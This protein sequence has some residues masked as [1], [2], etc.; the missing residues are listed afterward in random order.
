MIDLAFEKNMHRKIRSDC[1]HE[2]AVGLQGLALRDSSMTV[3]KASSQISDS[4]SSLRSSGSSSS[5]L[6]S[7]TLK[8]TDTGET[9][10]SSAS[11]SLA[12]LLAL[13]TQ[14]QANHHGVVEVLHPIARAPSK[15]FSYGPTDQTILHKEIDENWTKFLAN[16]WEDGSLNGTSGE[17]ENEDQTHSSNSPAREEQEEPAVQFQRLRKMVGGDRYRHPEGMSASWTLEYITGKL[18]N[19]ADICGLLGPEAKIP[20]CG[21]LTYHDV[22]RVKYSKEILETGKSFTG[23]IRYS[24][25]ETSRRRDFDLAENRYRKLE[26]AGTNDPTEFDV[27]DLCDTYE[28]GSLGLGKGLGFQ[29]HDGP[30]WPEPPPRRYNKLEELPS[31]W[32]DTYLELER[33]RADER[34][35]TQ[36]NLAQHSRTVSKVHILAETLSEGQQLERVGAVEAFGPI[37]VMEQ[38]DGSKS[39]HAGQRRIKWKGAEEGSTQCR[40]SVTWDEELMRNVQEQ[41]H[42]PSTSNSYHGDLRQVKQSAGRSNQQSLGVEQKE[43]Q[44]QGDSVQ[45][46][47]PQEPGF[48]PHLVPYILEESDLQAVDSAARIEE[49]L[50]P[51]ERIMTKTKESPF[52]TLLKFTRKITASFVGTPKI[53]QKDIEQAEQQ[54]ATSPSLSRYTRQAS[55]LI[56]IP[57]MGM[58]EKAKGKQA[59]CLHTGEEIQAS[60]PISIPSGGMLEQGRARA[61]KAAS[62]Y[63]SPVERIATKQAK[64]PKKNKSALKG[65]GKAVKNEAAHEEEVDNDYCQLDLRAAQIIRPRLR[66]GQIPKPVLKRRVSGPNKK[67]ERNS[68]DQSCQQE[69][70]WED[71]SQ[72]DTLHAPAM[73][74]LQRPQNLGSFLTVVSPLMLQHLIEKQSTEQPSQPHELQRC[75][76]RRRS[77]TV[78][79]IPSLASMQQTIPLSIE[80]SKNISKTSEEIIRTP[81]GTETTTVSIGPN[82]TVVPVEG[83]DDS[84]FCERTLKPLDQDMSV[85]P[86][87]KFPGPVRRAT[88]VKVMPWMTNVEIRRSAKGKQKENSVSKQDNPMVMR[89]GF[90]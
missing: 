56:A 60:R 20:G 49:D 68:Q 85:K 35:D 31:K 34:L 54:Q 77:D 36:Q 80:N 28:Y 40:R 22:L 53:Q 72:Q 37:K 86:S 39:Q 64:K 3:S 89:G 47:Q 32:R 65:K 27:A 52:G 30:R 13:P 12:K 2:V 38:Q 19:M 61:K 71:I 74:S 11:F 51:V 42:P 44:K 15:R 55:Q 21:G 50:R 23:P 9:S 69:S 66:T 84:S 41:L 7:R 57:G 58:S 24:D 6:A 46:N 83:I 90:N 14:P 63:S 87:N 70:Q 79:H 18:G 75:A 48:Q 59:E 81:I 33:C 43:E 78:I 67:N 4:K 25:Y 5:S 17:N 8:R 73:L 29:K 10:I 16:P 45:Y 1:P 76:S 62:N 82:H 88:T 26:T